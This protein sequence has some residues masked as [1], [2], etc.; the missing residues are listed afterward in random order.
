MLVSG[1]TRLPPPEG[2]EIERVRTAEEMAEAVGRRVDEASVV[3]MAAA[4]ADFRP[5]EVQATKIKKRDGA[6]V[7]KLRPTRDILGEIAGRRRNGQLV[8]GFAAETDDVLENAAA[9]AKAKRLDL[10]VANDVTQVGA[11]FDVDT[12]IVTLLFPDGR[13]KAL[14]MMSKFDVANRVLDE[15]VELRARR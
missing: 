8:V 1:P 5:E 3:L 9:K 4:V 14:E 7:V 13:R 2:V 12:N 6:P 15:V 11:G 10:V